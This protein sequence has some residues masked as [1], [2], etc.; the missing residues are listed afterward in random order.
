[1]SFEQKYLKYKSKYLEL[2]NQNVNLQKGGSNSKSFYRND[3]LN[4]D[5]LSV[6]PSMME[7]YGY[8]FNLVGGLND[9][10]K[11]LNL[12][13]DSNP[14]Q[15][16]PDSQPDSNPNQPEPDS[17]PNQPEPDS[18]PD[19]NP[20]QPEPDSQPDSNPNQPEPDSQS[21]SNPNQPEP[22]S[23]P[24]QSEPIQQGGKEKTKYNKKYFFDDS[25]FDLNSTSSE[26]DLTSWDTDINKSSDS[27]L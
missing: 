19:S 3:I 14:N 12:L 5:N 16:E 8:N 1:M 18:Q 26:Y 11:L 9:T 20:N 15:P 4:L 24:T 2:K 17:N 6:T 21:D 22:D 10:N 27:N 13:N 25:E 7:A 23:K